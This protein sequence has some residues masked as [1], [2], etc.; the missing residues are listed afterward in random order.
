[1]NI[2]AYK[3]AREMV[4]F[5]ASNHQYFPETLKP[6]PALMSLSAKS[7]RDKFAYL[8]PAYTHLRLKIYTQPCVSIAKL[9][10]KFHCDLSFHGERERRNV[11]K[12]LTTSSIV[13][14][15]EG[16]ACTM[17]LMRGSRNSRPPMFS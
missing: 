8:L 10:P 17:S 12:R 1:M 16:S 15:L 2:L 4:N 13:G 9:T 11:S 6:L 3:I 7:A 5:M 14:L